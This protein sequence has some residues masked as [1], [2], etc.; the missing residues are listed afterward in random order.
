MKRLGFILWFFLALGGGWIAFMLLT[1]PQPLVLD[2]SE[3]PAPLQV[4]VIM[5]ETY[6]KRTKGMASAWVGCGVRIDWGDGRPV[7]QP[8]AG[9]SCAELGQHMYFQ[10]GTF[11][12]T[13][14]L[15]GFQT[16]NGTTDTTWKGTTIVTVR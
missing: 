13:A 3:G 6:V 10:K 9:E 5:P 8:F 12:V 1:I 11:H 2:Q 14:F 7:P 15:G 4:H 16:P